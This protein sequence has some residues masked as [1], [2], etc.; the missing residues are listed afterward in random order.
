MFE[1]EYLRRKRRIRWAILLLICVPVAGYGIYRHSSIETR[2]ITNSYQDLIY[3]ESGTSGENT[4]AVIT[5]QDTIELRESIYPGRWVYTMDVK[6]QRDVNENKTVKVEKSV[7]QLCDITTGRNIWTMDL[8][9][10]SEK[11]CNGQIL[12]KPASPAVIYDEW[13]TYGMRFVLMDEES[14]W[15]EQEID[16]NMET[17][18]IKLVNLQTDDARII[19]EAESVGLTEKGS[20]EKAEEPEL[21]EGIFYDDII[22][23]LEI[24][25]FP[26]YYTKRFG[27]FAREGIR[28]KDDIQQPGTECYIET[29]VKYLPEENEKLYGEFPGLKE[30]DGDGNDIVSLYLQEKLTEEE[31][32]YLLMEDGEEITFDGCVLPAENSK[33]G[34]EREIHSFEEFYEWYI[35]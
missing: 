7:Y 19:H 5:P 6:Y 15:W 25:G 16:I 18:E 20:E 27:E 3:M 24:N 12:V 34:K 8:K 1:E 2:E 32:M 21:Q 17:R 33:D 4:M 30:Y 26:E 14:G 31:I 22:G 11:Y 35:F 23:V 29:L 13:G 9:E 28:A 10:L